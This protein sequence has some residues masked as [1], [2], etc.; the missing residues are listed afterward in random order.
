MRNVQLL[1]IDSI[2][3]DAGFGG[4]CPI[5]VNAGNK[6]YVLKT[7]EDGT[8]PKSLGLFNELLAYQLISILDYGIAPQEVVYLYID[9]DF[10]EAA[11]V[12]AAEGIIKQ[13][14]LEYISESKGVNLGIEYL[15]HAME[16]LGETIKNDSFLK[17][18]I[19]IDNYVMN[20]DRSQGNINILQDKAD[21]RR[22]YAIDFGNALA[23]GLMYERIVQD[24]E[25]LL[26]EGVY[27][28]CNATLSG[29]YILK[30]DAQRLI[31]K[32]RRLQAE[33]SNIRDI[34]DQIVDEFP[35]DWEPL[36]YRVA[37]LDIIAVR[38]K[39]KGIFKTDSTAKCNCL[40]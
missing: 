23:D 1:T 5:I 38:L 19:H 10:I 18:I 14:S 24:G 17:D 27:G 25:N 21:E 33:Y 39:S 28:Q 37:I 16:P 29:R 3:K 8:Q 22:Y 2:V 4:T 30:G 7:K 15:E 36:V 6:Q 31:K 20:C 40:Y 32:G 13:E 11:E 9:D 12:A 35:P 34:L 26:T